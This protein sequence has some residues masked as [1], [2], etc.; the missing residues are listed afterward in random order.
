M[1][2]AKAMKHLERAIESREFWREAYVEN[3]RDNHEMADHKFMYTGMS[4]REE[5]RQEC[6]REIKEANERISRFQRM[7]K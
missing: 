6:R 1:T 2:K 4:I 7:V 5:R 3:E